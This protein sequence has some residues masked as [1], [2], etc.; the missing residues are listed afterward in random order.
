MKFAQ[1]AWIMCAALSVVAACDRHDDRD[2]L[3]AAMAKVGPHAPRFLN[4]EQWVTRAC[5]VADPRADERRLAETLFAPVRN[6]HGVLAVWVRMNAKAPG[7]I[8]FP[9]TSP[10]PDAPR[11][12]DVRSPTLG[13][14]RV[15][16]FEHCPLEGPHTR[17]EGES[18]P[19]VLVSRPDNELTDQQPRVTMAFSVASPP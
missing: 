5:S 17:H 14:M 19:C 8:A 15:A 7:V 16:S 9:P 11:W 2:G 12:T 13:W 4:F 3:A 1:W 10:L 6:D 18:P